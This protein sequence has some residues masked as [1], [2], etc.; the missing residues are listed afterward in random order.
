MTKLY[1]FLCS[2]SEGVG[3]IHLNSQEDNNARGH[4]HKPTRGKKPRLNQYAK[5]PQHMLYKHLQS[6]SRISMPHH[7]WMHNHTISKL[8]SHGTK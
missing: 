1:H 8:T 3:F 5:R 6:H 4:G 7:C 2:T